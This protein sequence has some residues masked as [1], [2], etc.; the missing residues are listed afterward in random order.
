MLWMGE[1][2]VV[3]GPARIDDGVKMSE[4]PVTMDAAQAKSM[5]AD[6]TEV[7][8]C[9]SPDDENTVQPRAPVMATT[10]RRPEI[11]SLPDAP[12]TK[13]E[14]VGGYRLRL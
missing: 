5:I 11:P 3:C 14:V 1:E 10:R 7:W 6:E 9:M 12:N 4:G 8:F 13:I 2:V